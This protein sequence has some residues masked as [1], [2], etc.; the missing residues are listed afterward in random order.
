MEEH[1]PDLYIQTEQETQP[2]KSPV[3]QNLRRC[4]THELNLFTSNTWDCLLPLPAI[5]H[6]SSEVL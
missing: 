5:L 3:P 1:I 6:E 2:L 4:D